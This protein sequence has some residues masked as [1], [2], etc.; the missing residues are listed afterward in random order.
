MKDLPAQINLARCNET[1]IDLPLVPGH[2]LSLAKGMWLPPALDTANCPVRLHLIETRT[3]PRWVDGAGEE[4]LAATSQA[5]QSPRPDPE[6]HQAHLPFRPKGSWEHH[7]GP[8][9]HKG[10]P[11]SP[12]AGQ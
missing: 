3:L 12:R 1:E 5:E 2:N 8:G 9:E 7:A 10:L 4:S 11:D 6:I